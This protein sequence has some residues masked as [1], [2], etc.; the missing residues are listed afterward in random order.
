MTAPQVT[1]P[2]VTAP[3]VTAPQVTAPQVTA[4]QVTAPQVT[5]PQV[6]TPQKAPREYA[7]QAAV[8]AKSG[9]APA[10]TGFRLLSSTNNALIFNNIVMSLQHDRQGGVY[11]I[12]NRPEKAA[13]I[14]ETFFGRPDA[15]RIVPLAKIESERF[16]AQ[17][18]P[19]IDEGK[20]KNGILVIDAG[21]CSEAKL[22]RFV[23]RVSTSLPR[24]VKGLVHLL[25]W[26]TEPQ[27]VEVQDLLAGVAAADRVKFY[28][29]A[30]SPPSYS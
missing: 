17:L 1:A 22:Q 21:A 12:A 28:H 30:P 25:V 16:F 15:A 19:V 14:I 13:A 29:F 11:I 4:P 23:E 8:K 26:V 27:L 24:L 5:A 7:P 6:T 2:Q 10:R 9:G 3:Q 18:L 20:L